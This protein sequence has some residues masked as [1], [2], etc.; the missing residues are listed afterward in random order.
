VKLTHSGGK[1]TTGPADWISGTVD[2]DVTDQEYATRC[3]ERIARR[4]KQA[5]PHLRQREGRTTS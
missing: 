1:T 4:R 5:P 2:I 3:H